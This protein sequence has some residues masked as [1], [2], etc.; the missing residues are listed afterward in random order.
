MHVGNAAPRRIIYKSFDIIKE[1]DERR[2]VKVFKKGDRQ[3][4]AQPRK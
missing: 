4:Q 1:K 2:S 3:R